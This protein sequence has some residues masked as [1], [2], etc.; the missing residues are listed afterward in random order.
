MLAASAS[1]ALVASLETAR[2][3]EAVK[4]G[5][6]GPFSGPAAQSGLAL[7]QGMIVAVEE[8]NA[9]GGVVADNKPLKIEPLFEDTQS[10][11]AQGVSAAQ[12]LITGDRVN[13]LIGDAFASSVTMAEMDLADQYKIPMMSCEPVSGAISAKI[14]KDPEKYRYF[15]KADFNSQGYAATIYQTYAALITS[16][17]FTPAKKAVAF[18]VE[19]TDYGRSI[20]ANAIDLF[21][22]DGWTVIANN[23]VPLGNTNFT[24]ALAKLGYE[25]P[26]VLVS[27]FTSVDSGVALSKQF[28]EQGLT[29]SQFAI[30][31]PTRP[32]YLKGAGDAGEGLMWAPLIFDAAE[33]PADK[34][35]DEK[36]RAK[37]ATAASSDHAYGYDCMNIALNAVK[38]AGTTNPETVVKT[39]AATDYNGTLGHYVFDQK[40]H[41][42]QYGPTF[43]PIPTA[44]I[45]NGKNVIIWPETVATAKYQVQ[46]W[47]K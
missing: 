40:T 44:Q 33:R 31:Y 23:T 21:K 14:E 25:N 36:T 37:F 43:I 27:V 38:A 7:R 29:S 19:D 26:D 17:Q 47:M 41:T 4:I 16:G 30:Y 39:L 28:I 1:L 45:R 42:A 2:P 10:D 15:W 13:F 18:L 9:T 24:S 8:W 46:P 6:T 35:L 11:P 20:A 3:Q 34:L 22:A 32:T 5:V 12:K